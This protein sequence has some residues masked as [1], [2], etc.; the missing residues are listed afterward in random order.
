MVHQTANHLQLVSLT[1]NKLR[2][3]SITSSRVPVDRL[4]KKVL[5]HNL[6]DSLRG[7]H[8][9]HDLQTNVHD[10]HMTNTNDTDMYTSDTD[11]Y[12]SETDMFLDF[13]QDSDIFEDGSVAL[14]SM[15]DFMPLPNV[16]FDN[17]L[18]LQED[19]QMQENDVA[20]YSGAHIHQHQQSEIMHL[21]LQDLLDN[22]EGVYESNSTDTVLDTDMS[23]DT[24]SDMQQDESPDSDHLKTHVYTPN[25][26]H[27]QSHAVVQPSAQ[28]HTHHTTNTGRGALSIGSTSSSLATRI[29]SSRRRSKSAPRIPTWCKGSH[30]KGGLSKPKLSIPL[31]EHRV[32]HDRYGQDLATSTSHNFNTRNSQSAGHYQLGSEENESENSYLQHS[33]NIVAPQPALKGNVYDCILHLAKQRNSRVVKAKRDCVSDSETNINTSNYYD[34]G[35]CRHKA[36]EK[37]NINPWLPSIRIASVR[38]RAI[39]PYK[40]D[41]K[42]GVMDSVCINSGTRVHHIENTKPMTLQHAVSAHPY[43]SNLYSR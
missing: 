6:M 29:P 5:L 3:N 16:Y 41:E 25:A 12:T 20:E 2:N 28:A 8:A 40:T 17:D 14:N 22:D 23:T 39:S 38:L 42:I 35:K 15:D 19:E 34:E 32:G 43:K 9:R 18:D 11:M 4:R 36:P 13:H 1:R 26:T 27:K 31:Q 24:L 21:G 33:I 7:Q 30:G 10:H 37:S